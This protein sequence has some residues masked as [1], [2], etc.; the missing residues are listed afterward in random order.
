MCHDPIPLFSYV[1]I[2]A[3]NRLYQKREK[4]C[5]DAMLFLVSSVYWSNTPLILFWEILVTVTAAVCLDLFE[6]IIPET[7]ALL[8]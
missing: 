7:V 5:V 1:Q 3:L 2:E 6:V 8:Y 4:K